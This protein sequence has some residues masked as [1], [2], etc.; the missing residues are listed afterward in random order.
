MMACQTEVNVEALAKFPFGTPCGSCHTSRCARSSFNLPTLT[1]SNVP[2]SRALFFCILQKNAKLHPEHAL[3]CFGTHTISPRTTSSHKSLS[4]R[5]MHYFV[6][7]ASGLDKKLTAACEIVRILKIVCN[8]LYHT[9]KRRHIHE[10]GDFTS[11][12]NERN[13]SRPRAFT[14]RVEFVVTT[15]RIAINHDHKHTCS[16]AER[17]EHEHICISRTCF[18]TRVICKDF[19]RNVKV[20]IMS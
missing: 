2:F 11:C 20:V 19:I 5:H 15:L 13:Q 8:K 7:A 14:C 10:K 3:F 9:S 6:Q 1:S 16:G 4:T 18:A 17:R 12:A